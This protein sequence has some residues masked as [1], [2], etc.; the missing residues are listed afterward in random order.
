MFPDAIYRLGPAI[1]QRQLPGIPWGTPVRSDRSAPAV[2]HTSL[3]GRKTRDVL[4][5]VKRSW[6]FSWDF[7]LLSQVTEIESIIEGA[8]GLPLM[9][10]EPFDSTP[11]YEVVLESY[12]R[13]FVTPTEASVTLTLLEV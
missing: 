2:I 4:G 7:L 10:D 12:N 6:E 3:R 9:L 8:L 5:P 11:A 13:S 1:D